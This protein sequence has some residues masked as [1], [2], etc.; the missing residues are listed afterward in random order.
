MSALEIR[1]GKPKVL[2]IGIDGGTFDLI[3]PWIKQGELPNLKMMIEEGAH[4][5]L[6]STVHPL[7]PMAWSTFMTGKN[8]GKHGI[9]DFVE[10]EKTSY[11]LRLT[12]GGERKCK[13]I[14]KILSNS[15]KRL[16]IINVPY[17]YPPEKINGFM[18]SGYDARIINEKIVHPR[19]LYKDI[20]RN[21]GKFSV[22]S[23][24]KIKGEI[25]I[26]NLEYEITNKTKISKYLLSKYPVDLFMVC[27]MAADQ[28]QH[29]FW[30]NRTYR[31]KKRHIDDVILSIYKLIDASIGELSKFGKE[32][33]TIIVSDHGG[34][35]I[36][37]FINL[38]NWLH[39]MGFLHYKENYKTKDRIISKFMVLSSKAGLFLF[40]KV[41]PHRLVNAIRRSFILELLYKIRTSVFR[42]LVFS[43][44]DW[45]KTK[46]FSWEP[47]GFGNIQINL[48]G[49]FRR[50]IVEEGA[51]YNHLRETIIKELKQ[52]KDPISGKPVIEK[53]LKR[54]DLY[55]GKY[56]ELA[57]DI[58]AITSEDAYTVADFGNSDNE[59]ISTSLDTDNPLHLGRSI[60]GCHHPKG[61]FVC[62]GKEI[63]KG[64][65]IH[66]ARIE[67]IAPTLL[68]LMEAPIPSGMDGR[69]LEE[70]FVSKGF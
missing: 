62:S 21:A 58:I 63:K 34:Q 51:E 64:T 48:K 45:T 47:C 53:V 16:G 2:I 27:F 22:W 65:Q 56:T 44:I 31:N 67:D 3:L 59:I 28:A 15:G 41:L 26:D 5:I 46:A 70:I 20:L 35:P 55:H 54:E 9:F 8:P 29:F 25:C 38:N 36:K 40:T 69:V 66:G 33:T 17:T 7:T 4:G 50:G 61:I 60:S 6:E 10:I 43:D 52:L 49:V 57:P 12:D 11:S 13:T 32:S 37:G 23:T 42:N 1:N 14:W 68:H 30:K 39:K 24:G 18:I 19:W